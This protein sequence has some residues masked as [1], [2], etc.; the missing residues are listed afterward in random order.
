M[1]ANEVW[2][3]AI[4]QRPVIRLRTS[5]S[6][7]R[8]DSVRKRPASSPER[9]IVLPRRMPETES[10]SWTRLEMSA[11]DS[12]RTLATFRR[13]SPTRFVNQTKMRQQREREQGQL[14]VE[15]EHRDDGRQHRRH[16]GDDGRRGR[17]DDLLHAADVVRKP[18]LHLAGPRAGEEGE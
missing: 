16:V 15:D 10:D 11:I 13:W 12:C 4:I 6:A 7:R 17:C 14:P 2:I 8:P 3:E 18:R 5:R 9:P 1:I